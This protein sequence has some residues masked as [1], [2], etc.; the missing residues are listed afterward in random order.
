MKSESLKAMLKKIP[1]VLFMYMAGGA[2][3]RWYQL[4][5]E[6]LFDGSLVEGASMHKVLLLLTTTFFVGFAFVSYSLKPLSHHKDGFSMGTPAFLIQICTGI[7]LTV[8]SAMALYD[9]Q[10]TIV[11]ITVVSTALTEY[12]PYLG[13]LSGLLV[14]VFAVITYAG[15]TPSPLLYMLTSIYLVVRLIVYF[16]NWNMD[17]SSHDYAYKLLAAITSMLACF[18]I[19][20]FSFGKGKRRISVFW[21]LC[22]AFFSAVSLPDYW[23]NTP[24]LL[25]NAALLLLTL[26]HGLQLLFAPDPEEA[27][28][29]VTEEAELPTEVPAEEPSPEEH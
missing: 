9:P 12:L 16:Q 4:Q 18:H 28:E 20:G 21:C 25:V 29:E 14:I 26:T 23:E 13:L 17:P 1:F 15:R 2:F 22:A 27:A 3:C 5:N 19:S 24:N 8:G 6:L 7:L 10:E 11:S